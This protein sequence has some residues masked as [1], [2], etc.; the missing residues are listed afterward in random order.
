MRPLR[1]FLV[2]VLLLVPDAAM[3]TAGTPDGTPTR[4][5]PLATEAAAELAAKVD[6]LFAPWDNAHSPGCALGVIQDGRLVYERGY[7]MADLE[8]GVPITPH[9]AFDLASTSKQFT[10]MAILLL[11]EQGQLS[12]DDDVR[13][14]VP[15]VPD[16]SVTI[17]LR[18]L[19][20]H[21]SGLRN[22]FLLRQLT[23]WRWGDLV[24]RADELAIVSRQTELN[25]Q[26]GDE[27]S[28]TN[29][30][31]FL[32]GEVVRRVAGVSLREFAEQNIFGPLGMT[33]TKVHDDY[34]RLIPGRACAYKQGRD[35][36]WVGDVTRSEDVGASNVYSSIEDLARWDENFYD[37]KVGGRDVIARMLEPGTL[38]DGRTLAYAAGL[39]LGEY[40]GLRLVWHAGF[41]SSRSEFLRFP[42]QRFSVIC[43]SN[44]AAI[45]PS[46]LARKVAD[47]YLA[48]LLKPEAEPAAAPL[49]PEDEAKGRADLDAY[50]QAH[51][52]T[53]GAA[54]AEG[55]S[56]LAGL[57]VN[58]DDASGRRVRVSDGKLLIEKRR[59]G[60]G[61]LVP[62][63]NQR[64]VMAG[65]PMRLE[66]S[67]VQAWPDVRLLHVS[68]GEGTPMA[69][70]DAGAD[71]ALPSRLQDYAGTFRNDDADATVTM[72]VHD[73]ALVLRTRYSED[74][75]PDDSGA[76][77]ARGWYPLKP[78]CMDSFAN[79]WMGFLRFT[80]DGKQ[81]ITGFVICNFAGGVRHLPFRKGEER[82][83]ALPR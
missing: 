38:N 56:A 83:D 16:Y 37:A 10:A 69:L 48:D 36:S 70:I 47:L 24:T 80:R 1:S 58:P 67:F 51:A 23:G 33:D 30:G 82:F 34:S 72:A 32:L 35:G 79:D 29:T 50:I 3:Q 22:H 57:Y 42:D 5:S 46:E 40:K 74:P 11:A 73:G 15:E 25:F 49:S 28:Y 2:L 55:L 81:Q 20:H 63:G 76:G 7:G 31:Y 9:T 41:S 19:L 52:V 59:G 26:P 12:L 44:S 14:W 18:H 60:E 61:E 62:I 65:I 17:T 8:H 64:F 39:R 77:A 6:A 4:P 78:L 75:P 53:L 54:D 21:T 68:T 45:D 71:P 66:F 43:L 27:H 13:R